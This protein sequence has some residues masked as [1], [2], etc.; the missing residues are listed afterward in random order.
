MK[1]SLVTEEISADPE[2]AIELGIEWGGYDFNLI[3]LRDRLRAEFL[4]FST[5][6]IV[7]WLGGFNASVE[8]ISLGVFKIPIPAHPRERFS[9]PTL[10]QRYTISG[11]RHHRSQ[12]H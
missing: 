8:A 10:T 7:E 5:K 6:R 3:W 12:E 2:T 11:N 4:R 9:C 1:I